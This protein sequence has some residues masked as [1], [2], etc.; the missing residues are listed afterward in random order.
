[1]EGGMKGG[2]R[3]K[4][5]VR[6]S[7]YCNGTPGGGRVSGSDIIVVCKTD[8]SSSQPNAKYLLAWETSP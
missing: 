1:M 3:E 8:A 7:G 4:E 5:R 2:A 6:A